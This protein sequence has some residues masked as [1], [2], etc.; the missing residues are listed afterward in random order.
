MLT[1]L[2]AWPITVTVR[3]DWKKSCYDL[4]QEPEATISLGA[5]HYYCKVRLAI[6]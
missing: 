5:W 1:A 3:L 4:R 6:G 2:D